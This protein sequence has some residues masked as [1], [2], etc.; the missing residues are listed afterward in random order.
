MALHC[1]V[2]T[3]DMTYFD[4]PVDHV[5]V[6]AWNGEM[7]FFANHAPLIAQLGNGVLRAHTADGKV[8][9]V[10]IFGGF[11]KVAENTV[12]VLAGGAEKAE[13][14][15]ADEA[16]KAA[17][18]ARKAH[19][20]QRPP[21]VNEVEFREREEALIRAEVRLAAATGVSPPIFEPAKLEA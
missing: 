11:V 5:V 19:L 20:E 9:R 7:A 16:T 6:P 14:I 8:A 21:Q 2:V 10:A 4:A 15:K 3:P 17:E 13:N 1:R 12:L 18:A